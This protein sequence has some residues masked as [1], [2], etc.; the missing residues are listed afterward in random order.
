MLVNALI[1]A[2]NNR[3]QE[4]VGQSIILGW[5]NDAQNILA[6]RVGANFPSLIN[7]D[8]TQSTVTEPVWDSRFHDI[9]VIYA[10]A[11]YRESDEAMN[12]ASYL[13]GQFFSRLGD[14]VT[15]ITVAEE[16][17]VNPTTEEENTGYQYLSPQPFQG[18]W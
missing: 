14:A 12:E 1:T 17:K 13:D 4:E 3:L 5:M 11:R 10:C 15:E 2:V 8:G 18:G 6:A 9:L 7:S 16:Y